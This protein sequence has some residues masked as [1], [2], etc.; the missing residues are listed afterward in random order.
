MFVHVAKDFLRK[1]EGVEKRLEVSLD[2]DE[3]QTLGLKLR[4]YYNEISHYQNLMGEVLSRIIEVQEKFG[5]QT[6]E[7]ADAAP[8]RKPSPAPETLK[9]ARSEEEPQA[10]PEAESRPEPPKKEEDVVGL[11]SAWISRLEEDGVDPR[12]VL[13]SA[14]A[15]IQEEHQRRERQARKEAEEREPVPRIES[16]II[17]TVKP[18]AE[19][20]PAAPGPTHPG[21]FA[22]RNAAAQYMKTVMD[23]DEESESGQDEKSAR[24][25]RKEKKAPEPAASETAFP[26]KKIPDMSELDRNIEAARERLSASVVEPEE[27]LVEE[28]PV[29]QAPVEPERIE[30]QPLSGREL[31]EE[32]A[33]AEKTQHIDVERSVLSIKDLFKKGASDQLEAFETL[34][35]LCD[36][37]PV[38]VH[39]WIVGLRGEKDEAFFGADS[40][41]ALE[42]CAG[43]L[44]AGIGMTGTAINR[45]EAAFAKGLTNSNGRILLSDLYYIKGIFGKSLKGYR[46]AEEA[47]GPSSSTAMGIIRC[48]RETKRYAELASEVDARNFNDENER[49]EALCLKVE[50]LIELDRT[51]EATGL[52]DGLL[53]TTAKPNWKARL[54]FL[55]ARLMERKG[56][57][58]AATDCYEA[59]LDLD[60]DNPEALFALGNLYMTHKAIPLAKGR[61][62]TLVRK[63]PESPWADQAR[64]LMDREGVL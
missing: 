20:K 29:Y 56:D 41:G 48:L 3:I 42:F 24:A 50:A 37:N 14:G 31:A 51:Q 19:K 10:P 5:F 34:E 4:F 13:K 28:E 49:L 47:A 53:Q 59:S 64:A 18:V 9:E 39:D 52:L 1:I 43:C 55:K 25:S 33:S 17:E 30:E 60:G 6:E 62:S 46:D 32:M 12:E 45:L 54:T 23:T 57:A 26:V 35:R 58:V 2:R 22:A 15:T 21:F 63:F 61:L 7:A 8:L 44:A 40:S 16:E 11:V 27:P 38:D 36:A